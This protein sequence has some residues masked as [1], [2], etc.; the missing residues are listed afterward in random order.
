MVDKQLLSILVCPESHIPLA[1]ADEALIERVNEAI[2]AGRLSNRGG[3]AVTRALSEAL[4]TEDGKVLY[5]VLD[6]IPM[7]LID[8]GI[9]LDALG[10]TPPPETTPEG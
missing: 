5:P 2:R 3:D 8:E 4:V 1:E 7:L 9:V 10:E 6:G